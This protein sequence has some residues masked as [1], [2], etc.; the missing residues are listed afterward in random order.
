MKIG[1]NNLFKCL[2]YLTFNISFVSNGKTPSSIS[3]I[4]SGTNAPD[5][6]LKYS[7][8]FR[9]AFQFTPYKEE[10]CEASA[11]VDSGS[12]KLLQCC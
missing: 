3:C 2:N 6:T 9:T 10:K 12:S 4:I 5:A 8:L 7:K 11:G 1:C